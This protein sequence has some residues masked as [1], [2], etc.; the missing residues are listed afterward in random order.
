[1]LIQFKGPPKPT[2]IPF[3]EIPRK[4]RDLDADALEQ[5]MNT[6]FEE[7]SPYQE[8]VISEMY[9]RPDR[10]Y[11]QEPPELES[12]VST[13]KLVQRFLPKQAD[14]DKILKIIQRKVLKGTHL[15]VTIKEIQAGYL[16]SPYFH[17]LQIA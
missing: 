9:H 7:N 10:S 12:L 11:F 3:Q 16:I 5:G 13:G 8:N 2:E 14:I 17:T 15:P 1:M 6:D 4:F